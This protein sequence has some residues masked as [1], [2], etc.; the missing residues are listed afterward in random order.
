MGVGAGFT[1]ELPSIARG[2]V[3][4]A[5]RELVQWATPAPGGIGTQVQ[6]IDHAAGG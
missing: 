4:P 3:D 1:A 6:P 2:E 5:A